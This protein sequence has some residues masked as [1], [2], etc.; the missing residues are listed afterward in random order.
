MSYFTDRDCLVGLFV[1]FLWVL[2]SHVLQ[3]VG[4][5]I[6]KPFFMYNHFGYTFPIPTVTQTLKYFNCF[7]KIDR[8]YSF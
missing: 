6:L 1:W 4:I 5:H 3:R 7:L 2:E 8:L